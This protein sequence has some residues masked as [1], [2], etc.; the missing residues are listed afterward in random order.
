MLWLR[1]YR[2]YFDQVSVFFNLFSFLKLINSNNIL[3][4]S[5]YEIQHFRVSYLTHLSQMDEHA[6]NNRTSLFPMSG[7]LAVFFFFSFDRG[8]FK[9]IK[10][11][12]FIDND[13]VVS[14]NC[15]YGFSQC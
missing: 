1:Q 12:S 6:P 11:L 14:R 7:L 2:F 9:E 10:S 8:F 3:S 13:P 15:H 4:Y 5:N